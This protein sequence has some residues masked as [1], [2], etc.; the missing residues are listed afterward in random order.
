MIE[1]SLSCMRIG[2]VGTV[3]IFVAHQGTPH[4][5]HARCAGAV[6]ERIVD[7]RRIH[8]SLDAKKDGFRRRHVMNR[9][10]MVGDVF[11]DAAAAERSEI[12]LYVRHSCENRRATDKGC[13]IAAAENNE[14]LGHRLRAGCAYRKS[15]PSIFVMQSTQNRMAQNASCC[16]DGT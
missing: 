5:E 7:Q 8:P 16:L 13:S 15:S 3:V 12:A 10:E 14:I 9:D 2:A 4:L 11:H 1:M 6:G